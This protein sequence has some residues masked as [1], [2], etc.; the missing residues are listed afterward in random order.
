M[1]KINIV[2]NGVPVEGDKGDTILETAK[3]T[4][5]KIPHLCHLKLGNI[6]TN[7]CASCRICV[8]E[9]DG[10]EALYPACSTKIWEGMNI[11]TNSAEIIKIRRNVLELILANHPSSCLVCPKVGDCELQ[12]L[13]IELR[14]DDIRFEQE[15][16]GLKKDIS[17]AIIR[18][19]DKCIMCRRCETMCNSVQSC[20]IISGINRGLKAIVSTAFEK[21]LSETYC[22]FCGQCVAVCP[23]GALTERD[24][25]W[26]VMNAISDKN[27]IVVAQ[28]AP[29]VRVALGEEFDLKP[30]TNI[31][32]KIVT[33]L[34]ELGFDY[35][36]DTSWAADLTI[37]E[38]ASELKS[39]LIRFFNGDKKVKLP[40][41]TSCCPAWMNFL[42]D[43]FPELID[44]PS[45]AKS[46]MQMCSSVIKNIWAKEK[47]IPKKDV[48]VVSIMPCLA[49][50]Y[51]SQR[52]E[53]V[54]EGIP[55]TDYSI[56]TRELAHM[57]KLSYVNLNKLDESEF[58]T[59]MGSYSGAGVIFGRTG[60]VIEAAIRTAYNFITGKEIEDLEFT[61]MAGTE[62]TRIA[63]LDIEGKKIKI[64]ITHG[65]GEA[66]KLL[67]KV[68]SGEVFL[69]AIEIMACKG[70][71][72]GGGG[73]PYAHGDYEI[74][75]T[76]MKAL[77][78][79]DKG[80]EIRRSHENPYIIDIYKK[81]L[82]E[83]LS[84]KAKELLHNH[85]K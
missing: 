57:L 59:P 74:I 32:K 73:Q 46:P 43:N 49:K 25:T 48:V 12:K 22:T 77:S 44:I 19:M 60:G 81:Y 6:Y 39:R 36:F 80:L 40:L 45:T 14:I 31:E 52:E 47:N 72:V 7:D 61:S 35:V 65:L 38:E 71:C 76:R 11:V 51:E 18:D 10:R 23:V 24:Y 75:K 28:I 21:P 17:P 37:M 8:V 63:E 68:E 42:E 30:G 58:D 56:T 26:S 13:A 69:H 20:N 27:K 82:G 62:G 34:K 2:L 15:L 50:K 83:P 78:N 41:L 70:G 3:K 4:D 54:Y 1:K 64:G 67:E 66:R 79:I 85:K 5:V 9:V 29:A 84:D 16:R 53:Y 33:A 55:D